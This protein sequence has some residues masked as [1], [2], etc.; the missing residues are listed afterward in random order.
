MDDELKTVGAESEITSYSLDPLLVEQ[1]SLVD[2]MRS[3]LLSCNK[4]DPNC[5]KVAM[6]NLTVMRIIHQVGRIIKFTE[7]MD[8]LEDKLYESIDA[9]LAQMDEFDPNTMLVLLKVQSQLQ[10]SIIESQKLLQ[11]YLDMDITE[12]APTQTVEVDSFGATL[13]PKESRN[14]IR[15]GAQALLTELSKSS[16]AVE[17]DNEQHIA[18]TQ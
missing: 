3:T 17:S 12:F 10:N 8:R 5:A 2:N 11:P 7:V 14:T 13:I 6:Q 18:D 16:D 9:N 15:N 1:K 4:S